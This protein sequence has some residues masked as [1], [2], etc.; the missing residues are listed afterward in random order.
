MNCCWIWTCC[1]GYRAILQNERDAKAIW[2][3]NLPI[4]LILDYFFLG[5][6]D[7]YAFCVRTE[8]LHLWVHSW[9]SQANHA[10]KWN[11]QIH[12][13]LQY[14]SYVS[15]THSARHCCPT[16]FSQDLH[17]NHY[18]D[19]VPIYRLCAPCWNYLLHWISSYADSSWTYRTWIVQA[20]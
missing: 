12:E 6:V 13:Y 15:S 19:Y 4:C 2:D 11:P 17:L 18:P 20:S 14:Y 9:L 7:Q 1:Y 16:T 10:W 3:L 5:F 8:F